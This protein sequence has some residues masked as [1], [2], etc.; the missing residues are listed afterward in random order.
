MHQ[1]SLDWPKEMNCENFPEF[2]DDNTCLDLK[3]MGRKSVD[4]LGMNRNERLFVCLTIES[5]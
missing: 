4:G 1:H 2:G 5:L 3:A